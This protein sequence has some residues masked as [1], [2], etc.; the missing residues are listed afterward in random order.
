MMIIT[1][2]Y[3]IIYKL[4]IVIQSISILLVIINVIT[5]VYTHIYF[6]SSKFHEDG[7]ASEAVGFWDYFFKVYE[8]FLP[9]FSAPNMIG[10][11][12]KWV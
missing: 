11:E 7:D 5:I 12:Y 9:S 1:N 6:V 4:W 2:V 8:I 10:D 3:R